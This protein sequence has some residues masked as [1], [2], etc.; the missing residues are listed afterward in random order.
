MEDL[1]NRG[2]KRE[3]RHRDTWDPFQLNPIGAEKEK[4]RTCLMLMQHFMAVVIGL[5]VLTSAVISKGSLLTLATLSSPKSLRTSTDRQFY[6]LLLMCALVTPNLLVF[7]K[8]LWKCAFKSYVSPTMKI[9][10]IVS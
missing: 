9:L 1:R 8:C 4:K 3:G 7:L 5:L 10:G 6:T 2:Q